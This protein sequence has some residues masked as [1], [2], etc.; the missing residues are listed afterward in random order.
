MGRVGDMDNPLFW[1]DSL[2]PV[3][4]FCLLFAVIYI[5]VGGDDHR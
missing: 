5:A 3:V 4:L 2:G 1:A